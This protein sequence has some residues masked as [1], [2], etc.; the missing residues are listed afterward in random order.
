MEKINLVKRHFPRYKFAPK[1]WK[2]EHSHNNNKIL[3]LKLFSWKENVVFLYCFISQRCYMEFT[4]TS[5]Y[6]STNKCIYVEGKYLFRTLSGRNTDSN[7]IKSSCH[8]RRFFVLQLLFKRVT[9]VAIARKTIEHIFIL[10]QFCS[11]LRKKG[12]FWL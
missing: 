9:V 5:V 7:I 3:N 10:I 12:W 8:S 11:Y 1:K 6:T 4:W 2:A